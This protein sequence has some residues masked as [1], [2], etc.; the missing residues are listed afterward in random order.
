MPLRSSALAKP[1]SEVQ[2][3]KSIQTFQN[4][5]LQACALFADK[6]E[7]SFPN[8]APF[9]LGDEQGGLFICKMNA[10]PL[11]RNWHNDPG[12]DL[13]PN[14]FQV[15]NCLMALPPTATSDSCRLFFLLTSL[16]DS[17]LFL[18]SAIAHSRHDQTRTNVKDKFL[19]KPCV[20]SRFLRAMQWLVYRA[21]TS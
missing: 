6:I 2:K 12:Q 20:S 11:M 8:R 4:S 16:P 17:P 1:V 5:S 14:L 18:F 7:I 10:I 15:R 9:S 21:Q 13:P 19:F 3:K